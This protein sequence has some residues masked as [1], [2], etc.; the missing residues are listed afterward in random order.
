[1][2]LAD[3]RSRIAALRLVSFGYDQQSAIRQL[4]G[5]LVKARKA[6]KRRRYA[7]FCARRPA[8]VTP[9]KVA[10]PAVRHELF[11]HH[12]SFEEL[13]S[14]WESGGYQKAPAPKIVPQ[15][16]HGTHR[17]I[18]VFREVALR[19]RSKYLPTGPVVNAAARRSAQR[20]N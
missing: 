12:Y 5:T 18:P 16:P 4:E 3:I 9:S 1:M 17:G 8:I 7:R 20:G 11:G 19:S 2:N 14:M 10:A 15:I 6:I 13:F